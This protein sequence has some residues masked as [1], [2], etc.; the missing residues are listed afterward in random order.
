MLTLKGNAG[1]SN[2]VKYSFFLRKYTCLQSSC[3]TVTGFGF[4]VAIPFNRSSISLC[5]AQYT[6]V[7]FIFYE[8]NTH[9]IL[10]K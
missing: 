1:D 5:T 2:Y 7:L 6:S 8:K 4:C 9:P 10:F 3:E